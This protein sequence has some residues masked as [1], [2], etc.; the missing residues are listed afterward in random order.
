MILA[1]ANITFKGTLISTIGEL[2]SVGS[3]AKD[4]VLT[5]GDLSD[6]NLSDF[7]GKNVLL[8]IVPSL[9][10][11]V[12]ATSA[13]KFNSKVAQNGE[14]A[15]LVISADLPF[16]QSR[17]CE[18]EGLNNVSILSMFRS[19]FLEDYG[20]K[21]VDGPLA[22]LASRAIIVINKE[23]KV[24]YTEQVPEITQEPNYEEALKAL[25]Q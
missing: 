10:T 14:A 4:F 24:V 15:V 18:T 3:D 20:L 13:R 22:G 7:S 6:K 19:N 5:A 16:A 25:S 1:M 8:N 17:F 2:P 9:D 23:G 11:D 21:I 12:C